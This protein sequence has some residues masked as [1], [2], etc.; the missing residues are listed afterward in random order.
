MF[1]VL[2]ATGTYRTFRRL[3]TSSEMDVAFRCLLVI[4]LGVYY[5][6]KPNQV[7]IQI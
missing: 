3:D 4:Y 5:Y 1:Q 6:K 2:W 7:L